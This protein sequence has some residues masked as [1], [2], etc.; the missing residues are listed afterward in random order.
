M[1][2]R[3]RRPVLTGSPRLPVYSARPLAGRTPDALL[4]DG[5]PPLFRGR[6]YGL[7]A[8]AVV[9]SPRLAAARGELL[10]LRLLEQVAGLP[11]RR[12]DRH[13]LPR[14]PRPRRPDLPGQA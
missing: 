12:H 9:Q 8:A 5:I 6:L 1:L 7:L 10:L 14:R 2:Q 11:D 4:L 13:G 3:N